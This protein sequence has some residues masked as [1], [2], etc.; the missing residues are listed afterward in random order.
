MRYETVG[1]FARSLSAVLDEEGLMR[2]L[3]SANEYNE[4]PGIRARARVVCVCI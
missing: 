4:L 1:L 2:L 3:A